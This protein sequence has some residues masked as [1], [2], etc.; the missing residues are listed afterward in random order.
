MVLALEMLFIGMTGV[1]IVLIFLSLVIWGIRE[2][3]KV[4]D[5]K[6][7]PAPAVAAAS[8]AAVEPQGDKDIVAVLTAAASVACG[9]NVRIEHIQFLNDNKEDWVESGRFSL[10]SSHSIITKKETGN[11]RK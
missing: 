6:K 11:E 1:F 10:M 2:L 3:D 4:F 5:L 8:N 7:T 9:H